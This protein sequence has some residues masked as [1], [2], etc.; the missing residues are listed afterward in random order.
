GP[1]RAGVSA[2]G[3]SGTN[4]H[5]IIEEAPPAE[6]EGSADTVPVEDTPAP[7]PVLAGGPLVWLV[8]GRSGKALAAQAG[9]LL[10]HVV[11]HPELDPADVA[12][13]LA[14]TRS[15]FEHRAVVLG[16]DHAELVRGLDAVSAG[17]SASRVI[18]D[19]AARSGRVGFVFAGQGA[20][21]AGMGAELYAAS[22][23]FAAAFDEAVALLEAELGS[24]I[25]EVVLGVPDF[26]AGT[27]VA[28]QT[29]YAQ[30]GLFA[31]EVGLV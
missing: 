25:R 17:R 22:P 15:T 6:S 13:S 5:V 11:A 8:S 4:A 19:A 18:S 26:Q 3:I 21:R 9:R 28:D 14:T 31:V 7:V 27:D 20:Q 29:L 1:R 24:A 30:T 2:F 12:W 16:D 10:S 23:V